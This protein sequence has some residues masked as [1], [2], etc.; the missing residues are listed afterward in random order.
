MPYHPLR[1]P[2][3][4]GRQATGGGACETL[5]SARSPR[6]RRTAAPTTGIRRLTCSCGPQISIV[7]P[8]LGGRPQLITQQRLR[9]L[10]SLPALQA[11]DEAGVHVWIVREGAAVIAGEPDGVQTTLSRLGQR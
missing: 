3:S 8:L 9:F 6:L 2:S 1:A 7:R 11:N 4:R 5:R 10:N